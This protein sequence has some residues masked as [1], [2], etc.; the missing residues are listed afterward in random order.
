MRNR[1]FDLWLEFE[2]WIPNEADDP[3]D[4]FI[5]MEITLPHGPKYSLNVWT[6]K[7]LDRARLDDQEASEHLRGKYLLPPSLLV[8]RLER[9]LLEDIVRD[10]IQTKRLKNEWLVSEDK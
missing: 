4:D 10:L 8:E 3:E 9:R 6:F 7:F 1:E 5:N 2:H